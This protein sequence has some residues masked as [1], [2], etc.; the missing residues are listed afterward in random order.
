VDTDICPEPVDA[1]TAVAIVEDVTDVMTWLVRPNFKR[2]FATA[3]S[4]FV[5]VIVTAVPTVPMPGVKLLIVGNPEP[6][7]TAK[8]VLLVADPFGHVILIVPVVAPE[9]TV[10]TIWVGVAF[11]TDA[12][13]PL[14]LTVS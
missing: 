1:A 5:P 2:S 6:A 14:K 9:G 3:E 8:D 4:K 12:L 10:T 13:T 11:V 7:V